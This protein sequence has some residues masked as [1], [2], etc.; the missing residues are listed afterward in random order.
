[1]L[2]MMKFRL[3]TTKKGGLA[4]KGGGFWS[5]LLVRL[6]RKSSVNISGGKNA[7]MWLFVN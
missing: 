1:M 3:K 5:S 2:H 4:I 6:F 7:I